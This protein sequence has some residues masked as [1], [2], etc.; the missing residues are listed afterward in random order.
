MEVMI[1]GRH[2]EVRKSKHIFLRDEG[3]T[4]R[5]SYQI[6]YDRNIITIER[7]NVVAALVAACNSVWRHERRLVKIESVT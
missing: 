7:T 4:E 2:F 6:D 5:Q 3:V 1:A